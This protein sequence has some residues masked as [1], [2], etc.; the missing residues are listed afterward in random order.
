MHL[1]L[2]YQTLIILFSVV[3]ICKVEGGNKIVGRVGSLWETK[4]PIVTCG[5]NI[6]KWCGCVSFYVQHLALALATLPS[7]EE[8]IGGMNDE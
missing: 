4:E 7:W 2:V 5:H 3:D 1:Y 8:T 6:I